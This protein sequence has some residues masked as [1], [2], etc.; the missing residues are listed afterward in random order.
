MCVHL[1]ETSGAQVVDEGSAGGGEP[2]VPFERCGGLGTRTQV[3]YCF[4]HGKYSFVSLV[5]GTSRG[6]VLLAVEVQ[7]HFVEVWDGRFGI[8]PKTVEQLEDFS[9]GRADTFWQIRL[10]FL[11]EA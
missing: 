2:F 3:F 4:F 8:H 5:R 11:S 1:D 10:S 9:V 7:E 6:F